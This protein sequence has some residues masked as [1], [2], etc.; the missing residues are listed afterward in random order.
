MTPILNK[1]HPGLKI[2]KKKGSFILDDIHY[3]DGREHRNII[4]GAGTYAAMGCRLFLDKFTS[5]PA[6]M[7]T[8]VLHTGGDDLP[9]EKIEELREWGT[10]LKV[11]E[12]R[13]GH[14]NR[15]M[16]TY[17]EGGEVRRFEHVH[18]PP[19]R[20]E[21]SDLTAGEELARGDVYHLICSPERYRVL[22]TALGPRDEKA[23]RAHLEMM[24]MLP[25]PYTHASRV[26]IWEPN[27]GDC[28]PE[29]VETFREALNDVDIFSPNLDEL[30]SLLDITIDLNDDADV[31]PE[32][33]FGALQTA[34]KDLLRPVK[35]RRNIVLVIR[36]GDKGCYLLHPVPNA[37][38]DEIRVSRIPACK[39]KTGVVDV[40]GAGNAFLGG[41]AYGLFRN[42][43]S[44]DVTQLETAALCG[45]VAAS[46][47]IEQVGMPKL[48]GGGVLGQMGKGGQRVEIWND[49]FPME[50]YLKHATEY[51]C[52]SRTSRI[53]GWGS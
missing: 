17:D 36:L 38:S 34:C 45:T 7:I 41:F 40:T 48:L 25:P 19:N 1:I 50:R 51:S 13:N 18:K 10:G 9:L 42:P 28:K 43:I 35:R 39:P 15:G 30:C 8:H 14:T 6:S 53:V 20:V 47:A 44:S 23:P 33:S 22:N 31:N 3:P 27:E 49:D 46:F 11:V 21:G 52:A 4:G 5:D 16:N 2:E 26:M 37:N 29:A 32:V 24:M 12:S